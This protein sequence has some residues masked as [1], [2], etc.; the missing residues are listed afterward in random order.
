MD[1]TI[2]HIGYHKSAS[3]FLQQQVF[4]RLP[5]NYV[6]FA[7]DK[8]QYLDMIESDDGLD[9]N[10]IRNWVDQEI[11][12]K[13]PTGKHPT[14]VLSHEELSGHPHGYKLISPITT[15]RNLKQ[16]FPNAKILIIVRNQLDYLTSL[17]TFRVAIKGYET[18]SFSHFLEEEGK[19]GLYDHLEYHHLVEFYQQL[20]GVE[21]VAVIPMELLL[22]S[23][24][25]FYGR[26]FKFMGIPTQ[27]LKNAHPANVSTRS[28]AILNFWQLFNYLFSQ[29][30]SLLKLVF[31]EKPGNFPR[32][33]SSY[34]D[35]KRKLTAALSKLLSR[36]KQLE[37]ERLPMS[38]KFVERFA[39]SN[40]RLNKL[41]GTDLSLFGYPV[42]SS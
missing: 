20:F 2:I 39:E 13:Y 19:K 32:F 6:F 33:R 30:L 37:I 40:Y 29:I 14:T 7:G 35:L 16:T 15:A 17:Y 4:P 38:T 34:Y 23:P 41:I 12:R 21:R 5:V 9:S 24:D 27:L 8:R 1:S 3:T 28:I 11:A 18:R 36:S 31:G 22:K 10:L 25:D 26:L 42:K